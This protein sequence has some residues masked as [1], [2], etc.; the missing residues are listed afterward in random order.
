MTN[1]KGYPVLRWTKRNQRSIEGTR[2]YRSE[3]TPLDPNAL[4]APYD[5]LSGNQEYYVDTNISND[6]TYYY[7]IAVYDEEEEKLSD[8]IIEI[9]IGKE[10]IMPPTNITSEYYKNDIDDNVN[11]ANDLISDYQKT[12]YIT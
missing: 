12:E 9:P 6:T 11:G 5:F 4:P 7:M 1:F 2:I 3:N 8:K 10:L